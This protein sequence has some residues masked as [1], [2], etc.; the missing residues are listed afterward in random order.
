MQDRREIQE[1]SLLCILSTFIAQKVSVLIGKISLSL[2]K[3][4][5]MKPIYWQLFIHNNH[6]SLYVSVKY[7]SQNS[8]QYR[9]A[10]SS[11]GI[12][13]SYYSF[14][15]K[16]FAAWN[17]DNISGNSTEDQFEALVSQ[18]I[19][20]C[21]RDDGHKPNIHRPEV[22]TKSNWSLARDSSTWH[23]RRKTPAAELYCANTTHVLLE[24][25]LHSIL[26]MFCLEYI[27]QDT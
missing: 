1:T 9:R 22:S 24:G 12:G 26:T 27:M 16:A 20:P 15:I 2:W 17:L 4:S 7:N 13:Q 3:Q 21:T 5:D 14:W 19:I 23:F 18:V 25:W 8:G 11:S 10:V 6:I